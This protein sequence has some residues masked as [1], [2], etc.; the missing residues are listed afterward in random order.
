MP[1]SLARQTALPD[2]TLCIDCVLIGGDVERI[3]KYDDWDT[4]LEE[5]TET[6]YYRNQYFEHNN[7]MRSKVG[8]VHYDFE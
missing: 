4:T 5:C 2:T 8:A 7:L 3:K 6:F 1:I